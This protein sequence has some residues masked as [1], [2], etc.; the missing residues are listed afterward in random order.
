MMNNR[1]LATLPTLLLLAVT[2]GCAN[3]NSVFREFEVDAG[4]SVMVDIK[5]RAII[6]S[7]RT[8]NS[9]TSTV[10]CAEPSPDALSAYAAELA[11]EGKIPEQAAVQLAAAFQESSSFVGLRTQSIQLLRDS[12][13]RLCEGYMS[14][15]LEKA[16]YDILTRRYQKYM[17][18]LLGIE[19]L[20]GTVRV[21]AITINTQGGAEAARSLTSMRA[22]VEGIDAKIKALE[23]ERKADGVTD[24]RKAEI[25]TESASLKADKEA[26]SKAIEN[27]RGLSASG[28]SNASV[29][30]YGQP[31]LRGDQHTQ[32][33]AGAVEKIV[34]D[35]INSDDTGQLCFS[36]LGSVANGSGQSQLVTICNEYLTNIN[37]QHAIR[38]DIADKLAKI[39]KSETALKD[40]LRGLKESGLGLHSIG[41]QQPV[42]K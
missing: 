23:Q 32:A 27:A 13:Y 38:L 34:L 18:A 33:V 36:Y 25:D 42:D 12:L 26:V 28:S 37:K 30:L 40:V 1:S 21:P 8:A 22:E 14:G 20:T 9:T 4:K 19:Q 16:Q 5:Q 29:H 24:T 17:V 6:A 15:A 7:K 41:K 11:V 31:T 39:A 3:F 35:I 2:A 10:V